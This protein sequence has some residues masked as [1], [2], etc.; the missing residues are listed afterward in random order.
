MYPFI[1]YNHPRRFTIS[2]FY[3]F[4]DP[5][6]NH[7]PDTLYCGHGQLWMKHNYLIIYFV[8]FECAVVSAWTC[9]SIFNYL[10]TREF[11]Q[12]GRTLAAGPEFSFT[13][14]NNV[15][16]I[17]CK[18]QTDRM[19]AQRLLCTFGRIRYYVLPMQLCTIV[20]QLLSK[21]I[22]LCAAFR[23]VYYA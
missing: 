5:W 3:S 15:A 6:I 9:E 23:S 21:I 20:Q 13:D 17:Y 4:G 10:C 18:C 14:C 2:H 1:S 8:D 19:S 12:C 11:E 22:I 7:Y 16:L